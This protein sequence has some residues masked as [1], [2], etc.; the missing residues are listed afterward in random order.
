MGSSPLKD[1]TV[2][3][4]GAA[5]GLGAALV[6]EVARR[7]ARPV[8]LGHEKNPLDDLAAQ[9]PTRALAIEADVTDLPALRRA[10]RETHR[11]LG[12]PSVV[13]ANAGIAAGGLFADTDPAEWRRVI[14][15]NLTGSAQTARVFLPDLRATAGY[16]LQIA[17]LASLGAAP[18]MSAYC[19]SKAGVEAFAHA[20]RAEVAAHG[21]AVGI[22]Y[23]NWT[24]TDMVRDADRYAVLRELRGHM[25]G[26][27][28]RVYD[29]TEVAGRIV[30]GLEHR[31]TA[32]YAPPWL[33]LVQPVRAV[34]PPLV[35]RAARRGLPRLEA[36]DCLEPT[37]LLGAGG[38][39]DR[40]ASRHAP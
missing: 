9:L 8:L 14:D 29:V 5:R 2:V 27:A 11:R 31:R 33:R 35:L 24:D 18:L 1:R 6:R 38:D 21:V 19:A 28:R 3:V 12:T 36:D 17:S 22:A 32:V 25:P 39:A 26:P 40:A 23:P 10:A 30:D 13:I 37:G 15:V 7:G 34:L 4:T 20:L 16:Y